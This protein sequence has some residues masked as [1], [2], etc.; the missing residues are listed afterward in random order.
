MITCP[1]CGQENPEGFKFCGACAAPLAA[2]GVVVCQRCGQENPAG[3]K[4]CGECAAPLVEEEQ[5]IALEERKIVT[6]LFTD[7]VGSTAT[8]EQLDP[9]DVRARL[10][11]YYAQVRKE[12]VRYG[13]SVEKFIGDA[14]V[15]LFGA[16]VAHEDDAERAVRAALAVREAVAALNQQDEWLDLHLRTAVHT[17]EAIVVLGGAAGEGEGMAAGDVMNTAARIQGGAPVDGIVV[18]EAT[19]RATRHLFEY[20]EAPPVQAKGK[21]EAVPIW[22]VVAEK[23]AEQRPRTAL[24]LV[25]RAGELDQLLGYWQAAVSQRRPH[26]VT[27]LGAPGIGKSRLLVALCERAEDDG[28]VHWGRCLPYGEG[29]TYWPIRE[30]LRAAAGIRH[31]DSSDTVSGKL[32][33]LLESLPTDAPDELRTVAAAVANVLEVATTPRG[34]YSAVEIS[35]AE[36]HWGLRRLFQ[37]LAV[38]RPLLL[39]FE[40]LH[41]AEPTLLELLRGIVDTVGEAPLLLLGSARPELE[42]DQRAFLT[43]SDHRSVV[44]LGALDEVESRE[45]VRELIGPSAAAGGAAEKLLEHAAG[46]P[47]FLEEMVRMLAE[48]GAATDF[49]ALPIPDSLQALIGSRLDALTVGEKRVA[50]QASVIGA[51]FWRGAVAHLDGAG[52]ELDDRLEALERRDFVRAHSES[53]VVGDREY[54]FKHILIR[55]VAYE[56]LPKGKRA[57]LHIRFSEWLSA[58]T[59]GDDYV[60]ILAYHLEQACRLARSVAR[61]PVEPPVTAAVAALRRSAEKAERREGMREADR[62]YVRALE[63]VPDNL[64][65]TSELRLR[66]ASVTAAL[67]DLVRASRELEEVAEEA[68]RLGRRD[69]RGTALVTLANVETRQGR[70]AEA[71]RSVDAAYEIATA[72]GDRLLE[73]RSM[74]QSGYVRAWFDGVVEPGLEDLRRGLAIADDLGDLVLRVEGH[75]RMGTVLFNA[76]EVVPAGEHLAR[77]A[78]LA[79][80]LGSHRDEARAVSMLAFTKYY[81]GEREDAERLAMQALDWLERTG[82]SY[83]QLQNLRGLAVFALARRDPEAAE[84]WLRQALPLALEGGGWLVVEIYRYLTEALVLQDRLDDARELVQFAARNVPEEDRYA[85]AAL[86]LADGAVAAGTGDRDA[87]VAAFEEAISILEEQALRLDLAVARISFARALRDFD[88]TSAARSQLA[89]ARETLDGMGASGLDSDVEREL[90]LSELGAGVAGQSAVSAL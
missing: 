43:A 52:P 4:F 5:P 24:P 61:S 27:V 60:E 37:L 29:M 12:L 42:E 64:E 39:V 81:L 53:S 55:D 78:E 50:Q 41:W 59:G 44:R 90:A 57:E 88:A 47:L 49:E 20:D 19:Y 67:G 46:N 45:L 51:V 86:R 71:R 89:L 84:R 76:G 15:A 48:A 62:F 79:S 58:L 28:A 68:G 69:L 82:D 32:G 30:I 33:L 7:I 25:G 10:A 66:R 40:D 14:V 21:S 23:G 18:G 72:L 87:A 13:G 17:G 2:V 26:L 65:A 9:E 38:S 6:A 63:L 56:R 70:G 85:R 83:F 3:F 16:P 75:M 36:L 73:V 1:S 54:A 35:Q 77:C 74:F 22:E 8:A 34:T 31:D 80:E 11:P